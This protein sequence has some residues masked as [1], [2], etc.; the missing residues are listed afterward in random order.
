MVTVMQTLGLLHDELN[1]VTDQASILDPSTRSRLITYSDNLVQYYVSLPATL[2]FNID[3]FQVY[4]S[5]GEGGT[6]LMLHLWFNAVRFDYLLMCQPMLTPQIMIGLHHPGLRYGQQID[7][8]DVFITSES[9]SIALSSA[10][11][12]SSILSLAEVVSVASLLSSPFIDQAVEVA[13]LAFIAE[14][15]STQDSLKRITN[16]SNYDVCLR[17]LQ[18][19][20]LHFKGVGWVTTT[21][22]QKEKGMG[23]TDPAEGSVDPQSLIELQDTKM[24]QKL[25]EKA[26]QALSDNQLGKAQRCKAICSTNHV[27]KC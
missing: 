8:K 18:T 12:I 1:G 20:V 21:M 2:S 10:R 27:M 4:I 5:K 25:L 13:G 7:A 26:E 11:T 14:L 6:F 3:N 9:R 17:T 16:R 19:L 22:Q 15:A 24:I 23:E